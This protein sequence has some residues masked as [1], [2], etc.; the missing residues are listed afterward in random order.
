MFQ[1]KTALAAM[2]AVASLGLAACSADTNDPD[3][4]ATQA[5]SRTL[6]AM[7]GDDGGFSVVSKTMTDSGLADVFDGNAA[8][9][10]FLPTDEAFEAAEDGAGDMAEGE[11]TATRVAILRDHIVTGA[12]TP[13]DILAAIDSAESGS[14]TMATMGDQELTFTRNGDTITIAS[15][16]GS[17]TEVSGETMQATNGVAIPVDA[18]LKETEPQ[19][20]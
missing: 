5:S 10:I 6:A 13:Q 17:T 7:I 12:F 18:V 4:P 3:A 16:D 8:Y 1:R 11:V 20:G 9:T 14:V 2:L 19:T 15:S